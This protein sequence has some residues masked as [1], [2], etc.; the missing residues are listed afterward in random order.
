[1]LKNGTSLRGTV[2]FNSGSP[3]DTNPSK[4]SKG[5]VNNAD[6]RSLVTTKKRSENASTSGPRSKETKLTVQ[7]PPELSDTGSEE[8]DLSSSEGDDSSWISWFCR[9]RG[10]ELLCEVDEDY[11]HDD[12][13]L[14]GLPG[15]VP[16]YDYALDMILDND[17]LSG[18]VDG[19]EHNEIESAAEILYG[20]IHAR[21]ILTSKGL[22]AMHEKYKRVDFGRCPRVYCGGQPCLPVGS[23]DIPRNGSVKLFCPKCEDIYFPRCKYQSNMDGA[24]IGTTF[25]HLYLLTYPNAKPAKPVQTYVPRVFGFKLHKSA[26]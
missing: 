16:Y 21:Y 8:T 23:S 22:A 18:E 19:E 12:F 4:S 24:Y 6:S 1:M 17:S 25:P 14:C 7:S 20:L 13:N 3:G 2:R 9:L 15:Q 5:L 26:R 10:N 11:I